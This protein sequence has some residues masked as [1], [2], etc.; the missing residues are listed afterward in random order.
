MATFYNFLQFSFNR[1]QLSLNTVLNLFIF[2]G[3]FFHLI[4]KYV[5]ILSF[6]N[7]SLYS[8]DI[9][10]K[11]FNLLGDWYNK[12]VSIFIIRFISR[13]IYY[14]RSLVLKLLTNTI[15]TIFTIVIFTLLDK[16]FLH[17][18]GSFLF[19]MI[20]LFIIFFFIQSFM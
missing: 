10:R 12:L 4:Y 1:T 13:I 2:S 6:L 8:F 14:H 3:L 15:N 17:L 11:S 19:F 16:L 18:F 5:I 7:T 9:L 20:F